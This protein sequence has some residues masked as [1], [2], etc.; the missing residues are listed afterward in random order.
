MSKEENTQHH[1]IVIVGG[2]AAG[3]SVAASLLSRDASLK[4]TI[5]EPSDKHYYQA[6]FTLVG[7]DAFDPLKTVRDERRCIPAGVNWVQ[8]TVEQLHPEEN[9]LTLSPADVDGPVKLSYD[10]LV[11]CPGL[12]LKW[13]AIDGLEA[14][15]GKNGVCS[16]Y[17]RE[18]ALYTRECLNSVTSGKL[19]FTQPPMPIK[20]AGAPQKIMYLTG[21]ALE[22]KGMLD[23]FD[24]AFHTA[25][26]ALFGVA[27]FVPSLMTYIDRY[28]V[29]LNLTSNLVA[30]DGASQKATFRQGDKDLI[31]DFEVIHV[32]PPQ[33]APAFIANSPCADDSGW[34]DVD[35]FTLQSNTH[36]NVF[37][38]GDVIS[39]P[40]A[41]TAAAVRKQ[42]PVVC[43]NLLAR[44][45]G[46]EFSAGYDGYGACPL[47]VEHGKVVLAEF[48]Y[49]GK[50]L[51]SFPVDNTRPS[52][53]AWVLKRHMMPYIYW[54]LM[55]KGREWLA[56]AQP[57]EQARQ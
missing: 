23:Q 32:V 30:I 42:V 10:Y 17:Q 25:T 2:G 1:E 16:N 34:L 12:S 26:P 53:M 38:L 40:N 36:D 48:G 22:R 7:A 18:Y 3:I 28:R 46:R 52:K 39:A 8:G 15:I 14:T 49:G 24:L 47:T 41:K 45:H 44:M 19:V 20:C 33:A 6:A 5:V 21:N 31:Q 50:L 56:G 55:L 43:E 4:L 29:D 9:A 57:L 54:D 51:P 35:H 13:D 37:G 27:D 11:V